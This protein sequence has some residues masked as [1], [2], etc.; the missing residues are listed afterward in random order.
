MQ[1]GAER[2]KIIALS[3]LG[4]VAA[5]LFYDNVL[6]TPGSTAPKSPAAARIMSTPAATP[7]PG[8]AVPDIRRARVPV[9]GTSNEFRPKFT[10]R[11]EDKPNLANIDPKL[12]LALLAKVQAVEREGGERNLFQFGSA[13]PPPGPKGEL[14]A[15]GK[16]NPKTPDQIA[17]EKE[18]AAA[19]LTPAEPVKQP[20]PNIPLRY[21]GYATP[22]TTGAKRAFF[23][24]GEDIY[25]AA[26]GEIIKKRYKLIRIGLTS[27]TMEDLDTKNQQ[28]L[29]ILKE[30]QAG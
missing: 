14:V 19:A 11:A 18:L 24:E 13:P 6:A 2:N 9:R 7:V 8:P 30:Q 29:I 20:P 22:K 25:V 12:Q 3:V 27:V 1:V 28:T 26:E 5:Y 10:Q 15:G 16:I 21:F 17:K 4:V 23:M